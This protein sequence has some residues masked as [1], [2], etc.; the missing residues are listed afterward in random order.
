MLTIEFHV[1]EH[2]TDRDGTTILLIFGTFSIARLSVFLFIVIV[3][4]TLLDVILVVLF[5][6]LG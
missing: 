2:V 5:G 3:V 4:L 6:I 1:E